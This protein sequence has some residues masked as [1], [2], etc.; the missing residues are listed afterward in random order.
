M[1]EKTIIYKNKALK[2]DSDRRDPKQL[3]PPYQ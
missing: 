2:A 1:V 3:L